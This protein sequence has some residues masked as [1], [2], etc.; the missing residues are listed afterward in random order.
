V[1]ATATV[2]VGYADALADTRHLDARAASDLA[3]W[4][5]HLKVRRYSD[6][7]I[8]VYSRTIA[9]LLRMFPDHAFGDFTDSNLEAWLLESGDRSAHIDKSIANRWFDWGKRKRRIPENPVDYIDPIRHPARRPKD[10]FTEGA[11]ERLTDLPFPN[12]ELFTIMFG[13]GARRGDCRGLRA[14]AINQARSRLTF[15]H[16]KGDKDRIVPYE[17]PVYAAVK[18]LLAEG[19]LQ[20]DE[21]VWALTRD[22]SHQSRWWRTHPVSDSHFTRWYDE[23][24]TA[25]GV[26]Y[27]NPHQTRHTYNW[28][29]RNR[30][31]GLEERAFLMG[32]HSSETTN[33]DYGRLTADDVAA[34]LAR[35][36]V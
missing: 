21:Y 3:D 9:R 10:I 4:L 12:G 22:G 25:A 26:P 14:D 13:T 1:S 27:L 35:T 16:G 31:V 29:L 18:R 17:L 36:E 33:R 32:H 20:R 19:K 23:C 5:V 34:V 24:I 2:G 11:V 28:V 8:Y 15:R 7:S 6:R 30:G